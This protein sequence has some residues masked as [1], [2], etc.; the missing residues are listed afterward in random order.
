MNGLMESILLV[1][2]VPPANKI[3]RHVPIT[4]MSVHRDGK[5]VRSLKMIKLAAM[6]VKP[7]NVSN[8][9]C[10]MLCFVNMTAQIDPASSS[11]KRDGS[12]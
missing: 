11:H 10:L 8:P 7:Q 6:A 5:G 12:R 9:F 4:G 2:H 1:R 3:I